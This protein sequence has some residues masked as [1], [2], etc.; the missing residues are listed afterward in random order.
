MA[1]IDYTLEYAKY[2]K[3]PV[4][5][6]EKNFTVFDNTQ[7]GYVKYKLFPQQ[8]KM[9]RAFLKHDNNIIAKP[10]QA[11]VSMTTAAFLSYKIA[12]ADPESP[13]QIY[14]LANK[15]ATA[16]QFLK[17]I[18]HFSNQI[19][20]W[21][22]GSNYNWHKEK[23]GHIVGKGAA[24][25]VEFVNGSYVEAMPCTP[26]AMRGITPTYLVIDEAAFVEN[27]SDVYAAAAASV[28]TGGN[29]ILISTPN[30]RDQLYYKTYKNAQTK[31]NDYNI[32]RLHWALDPRYNKDLEW[33]I[34]DDKGE[35]LDRQ[36]E[37]D[38]SETNILEKLK[39]GFYPTS[40]WFRKM[41]RNMNNDRRRIAQ[42]LE[43]KFEGSAANVIDP[44][45]TEYYSR[46]IVC[47]PIRVEGFDRKMW[48]WKDPQEGHR[49]IAGLD[50][51]SGGDQDYTAFSIID[52]DEMEVVA[53]YKGH[54]S[55]EQIADIVFQYCNDYKALCVVDRV[56]GYAKLIIHLLLG[57]NFKYLYKDV[58]DTDLTNEKE[59][60]KNDVK[61]GF[62][63]QKDR[64]SAISSF[65]T[66]IEKKELKCYSA[67]QVGEWDTYIWKNGRQDHQEG[68]NDDLIMSLVMPV[69]ISHS[70]YHKI[71][72]ADK[73]HRTVLGSFLGVNITKKDIEERKKIRAKKQALEKNYGEHYWVLSDIIKK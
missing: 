41:C 28:A 63:I 36:K 44:K 1:Q 54:A 2:L 9:I 37:E 21:M 42:E 70:V 43:V 11:G 71:E 60:M 13:Q 58:Y 55:D 31:E 47:D 3:D 30:G 61:Y 65:V 50:P 67:R 73:I 26:D 18:R 62:H 25:K 34:Y 72:K 68:F 57:K 49:Y 10:R 48:I 59:K 45:I 23:D 16:Q 33:I 52:L 24:K 12:T 46:Q 14:I 29:T 27:G 19:P 4:Y 5:F 39:E 53:E 66:L 15:L 35:E 51:S 20:D 32:V 7:K 6:I 64:Y 8:K 40:S 22:W 17:H 56:G 69:W 38:F